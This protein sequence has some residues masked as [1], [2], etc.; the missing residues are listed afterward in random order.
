MNTETQHEE[1]GDHPGMVKA[2]HIIG[3]ERKLGKLL[4]KSRGHLYLIRKGKVRL[5]PEL[6]LEIWKLTGHKVSKHMLRPD[7]W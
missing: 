7:I 5:Q 4:G 3:S 1:N 2:I 6:A